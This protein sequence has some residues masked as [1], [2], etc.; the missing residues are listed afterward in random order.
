MNQSNRSDEFLM[1]FHF[2]MLR[3][4][5]LQKNLTTE[6]RVAVPEEETL[7]CCGLQMGR[8]LL[9]EEARVLCKTTTQDCVYMRMQALK[10]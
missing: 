10:L 2:Q 1:F 8:H 9:T 6:L 7:H 5:D 4:A 3:D